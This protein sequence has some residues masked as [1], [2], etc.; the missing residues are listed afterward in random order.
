MI[1]AMFSCMGGDIVIVTAG[2]AQRPRK[3]L[4][5]AAR[6]MYLAPLGFYIVAS[7]LVGIVV[8]Y[9]DP[10]L[11]HVYASPDPPYNLNGT[12]SP[13]L[14]ALQY[15][16]IPQALSKFFNACFLISAYTAA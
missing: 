7:I 8:N 10:Q 4:P 9:G 1:L 14:I 2:E 13:F 3:D 12:H 5:A 16:T 6:F 11:Y 15:T